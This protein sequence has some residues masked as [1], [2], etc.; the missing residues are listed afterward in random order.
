MKRISFLAVFLLLTGNALAGIQT[1]TP[2]RADIYDLDHYQ[3]Y[4]WRVESDIAPGETITSASLT[5]QNIKNWKVENHTLYVNLL[6]T[7]PLLNT[8][9]DGWRPYNAN[10]PGSNGLVMYRSDNQ[11]AGNAFMTDGLNY[12]GIHLLATYTQASLFSPDPLK[13]GAY[14]GDPNGSIGFPAGSNAKK[15]TFTYYFNDQDLSFL[16]SYLNSADR[17]LGIGFDPDCKYYNDGVLFTLQTGSTPGTGDP[18]PEPATLLLFGSGLVA[19]AGIG[20]KRLK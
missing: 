17:V 2:T 13:P 7:P 8:P 4:S 14:I 10:S 20:R 16:N 6:N 9:N 11:A 5:F 1:F 19:L 12:G 18:I 15:I 3:Y